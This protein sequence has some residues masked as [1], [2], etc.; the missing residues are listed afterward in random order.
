MTLVNPSADGKGLRCLTAAKRWSLTA[1]SS[2][3]IRYRV[4]INTHDSSIVTF[5]KELRWEPNDSVTA[6]ILLVYHRE[7]HA[8]CTSIGGI[9]HLRTRLGSAEFFNS[10]FANDAI[11]FSK[12]PQVLQLNPNGVANGVLVTR[13]VRPRSVSCQM[14]YKKPYKLPNVRVL[15][16]P[17]PAH[18]WESAPRLK[19]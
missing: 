14:S 10:D 8:P 11:R 19:T 7:V 9:R 2:P 3:T 13:C 5:T 12:C 18:L 6:L 16:C 1:N 15:R 4:E 17:S